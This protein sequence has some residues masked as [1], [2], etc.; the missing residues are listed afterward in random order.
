MG[1]TNI[2][3]EREHCADCKDGHRKSLAFVT[4]AV[5]GGVHRLHEGGRQPKTHGVGFTSSACSGA[6]FL[7]HAL[8][9]K[10]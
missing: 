1:N 4:E 2:Q 3:A 8:R 6:A 5:G 10:D 7:G 9:G